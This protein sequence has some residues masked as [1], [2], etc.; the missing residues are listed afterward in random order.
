MSSTLC[1]EPVKEISRTFPDELK[2]A[3]AKRYSDND[4]SGG[5]NQWSMGSDETEYVRGLCDAG[6][7]G[8]QAL[9]DAMAK[10]GTVFLWI[11]A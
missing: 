10:H 2:R 6:V 1:W 8:A 7:D 3:L 4:G 5:T 9:L 11:E